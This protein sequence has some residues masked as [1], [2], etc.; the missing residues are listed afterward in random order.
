M[1][2]AVLK[3]LI[4]AINPGKLEMQSW[5]QLYIAMVGQINRQKLTPWAYRSMEEVILKLEQESDESEMY[6]TL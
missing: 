4:M 1:S 2:L 5:S 3:S 6:S